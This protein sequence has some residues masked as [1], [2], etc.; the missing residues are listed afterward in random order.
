MKSLLSLRQA[1]SAVVTSN[2]M[3]ELGDRINWANADLVYAYNSDTTEL[4]IGANLVFETGCAGFSMVLSAAT[5]VKYYGMVEHVTVPTGGYFWMAYK[6]IVENATA[7][8]TCVPGDFLFPAGGGGLTPTAATGLSTAGIGQGVGA[9]AMALETA[10]VS[11]GIGGIRV[12][13]FGNV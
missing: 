12:V 13:Y 7:S 2:P 5:S 8:A 11:T 6:G 4:P 1:V 10:A 3:H 9:I